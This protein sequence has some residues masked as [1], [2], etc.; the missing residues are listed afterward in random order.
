VAKAEQPDRV[1]LDSCALIDWADPDSPHTRAVASW[2]EQALAGQVVV[3]TSTV[4]L[5]EARG[6]G[7]GSPNPVA[8]DRIRKVLI[9]PAVTL[10]DCTRRVALSARDLAVQH[11]LKTW[12]AVHLASALEVSADV[13]FTTDKGLL[14]LDAAIERL[15][16]EEPYIS[17]GPNL[18]DPQ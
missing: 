10:V 15:K 16:I 11:G 14:P 8:E 5:V 6:G 7:L 17:G 9:S 4:A 1:Y 2:L 3:A 18:F 13:L 12:D